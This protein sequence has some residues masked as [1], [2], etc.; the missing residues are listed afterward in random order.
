MQLFFPFAIRYY[1]AR[2]PFFFFLF[3]ICMCCHLFKNKT[4]DHLNPE[5]LL[6]PSS[7]SQFSVTQVRWME[8][9]PILTV[10]N[11]KNFIQLNLLSF[12]RFPPSSL[13]FPNFIS[14]PSI[15]FHLHVFQIFEPRILLFFFFLIPFYSFP[16]PFPRLCIRQMNYL[17]VNG[18]ESSSFKS[19]PLDVLEV[20]SVYFR[21]ILL[22]NATFYCN[23]FET[24][25]SFHSPL[26]RSFIINDKK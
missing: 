8:V 22:K 25:K 15:K 5:N 7:S 23:C 17:I 21:T 10:F 20:W 3:F 13:S 11:L 26:S 24:F 4:K 12:L 6:S 19:L 18:N 9:K 16:V 14:F 1:W 2:K